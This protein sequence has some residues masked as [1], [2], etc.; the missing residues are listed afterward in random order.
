MEQVVF[1]AG[2]RGRGRGRGE[3]KRTWGE[4]KGTRG[5]KHEKAA[6]GERGW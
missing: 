1:N 4:S 5:A 6:E 3:R 2:R